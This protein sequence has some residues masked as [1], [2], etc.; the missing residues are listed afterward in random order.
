[1]MACTATTSGVYN[2]NSNDTTYK[3]AFNGATATL[4]S[5]PGNDDTGEMTIAG[6]YSGSEGDGTVQVDFVASST[7]NAVSDNAGGQF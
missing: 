1:M 3:L 2:G 7:E 6:T 5:A 4:A